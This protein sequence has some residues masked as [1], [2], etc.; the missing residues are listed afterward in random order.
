MDKI[1]NET[2]ST[3]NISEGVIETITKEAIKDVSGVAGLEEALGGAVKIS[4]NSDV[5]QISISII[6]DESAK[7]KDMCEKL[8]N[9]VKSTVQ[10]M[11]GITVSKVNILVAGMA[12]AE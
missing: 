5:C 2:Q 3:L 7:L 10:S 11:T 4:L 9:V 8:Q 1:V 12:T 6:A